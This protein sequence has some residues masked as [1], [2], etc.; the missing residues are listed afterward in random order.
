MKNPVRKWMEKLE[1]KWETILISIC[2]LAV[3][4]LLLARPLLFTAGIIIAAGV[5]SILIGIK[6]GVIYFRT[7]IIKASAQRD[8]FKALVLTGCGIFLVFGSE[9]LSSTQKVL[10]IVY[11]IALLLV[12]AEKIQWSL[13]LLRWQKPYWYVTAMNAVITSVMAVL[14]LVNPFPKQVIWVVTGIVLI[15]ESILDM[16]AL[17]FAGKKTKVHTEKRKK[18]SEKDIFIKIEEK[19]EEIQKESTD[20][21]KVDTESEEA[22]K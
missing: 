21:V 2:E 1:G 18:G 10:N 6:Y 3:G 9:W 7:D 19:T 8:V 5:F 22:G 4:I 13:N 11:G 12:A 17:W 15:A 16:I 14:M 20:N